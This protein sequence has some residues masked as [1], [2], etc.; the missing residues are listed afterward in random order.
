MAANVFV[1]PSI[2]NTV[3]SVEP[4]AYILLVASSTPIPIV[5]LPNGIDVTMELVEAS[6]TWTESEFLVCSCTS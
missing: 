3:E 4:P 6:I 5:E 2:T 1:A